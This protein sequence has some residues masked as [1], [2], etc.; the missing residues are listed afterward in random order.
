MDRWPVNKAYFWEAAP[1]FR[2][3][4]PF[5]LGILYYYSPLMAEWQVPLFAWVAMGITLVYMVCLGV[6]RT[7][8]TFLLAHI[9]LFAAG[10]SIS[11]YNDV[12][13]RYNW[14]GRDIRPSDT[15]M[16]FVSAAPQEKENTW[17]LTVRIIASIDPQKV[18]NVA[19]NAFVYVR[20][21]DV[22]LMLHKGD[23]LLLPGRW[24]PIKDAGNPFEFSY[25]AYCARNN[26]RHTQ[27]CTPAEVRLYA[28]NNKKMAAATE[29]MHDWCMAQLDRYL[30]THKAR[31][32]L[33]AMLMG[34]EVNL[35]K[36]LQHAYAETGIVHIIAIS[37]GNVA[38]FFIVIS[39][40]LG[41]LKHKRYTW[42]KYAVAMPI[43]W[44][45][46]LAAGAQPS[47]VRA[48][49]MFSLLSFGIIIRRGSNNL[50]EL[51]ATAF[52]L[53]CAE[54]AWLLS[55]GFQLSFCAVLSIILFYRHVHAWAPVRASPGVGKGAVRFL[56]R[57]IYS[58]PAKLWNVIAMSIAAEILIAP[59]VIYYFHSFP[60]MFIV[61]NAAAYLFMSIVLMQ[62][63]V[64]LAFSGI[65]AI[66]GSIAIVIQHLTD[67]FS[68]AVS[69]MQNI[70]PLSFRHISLSAIE[71]IIL[72][73]AVADM[74]Y[75][76]LRRYKPA[77]FASV[78]AACLLMASLCIRQWDT[79]HQRRLVVY[80]MPRA[81]HAEVAEGESYSVIGAD[82]ARLPDVTYTTDAAHTGWNA[83]EE[84]ASG[85]K[86]VC[87]I[88][89]KTLL[90]LDEP[91]A[92]NGSFPVDYLVLNDPSLTDVKKLS[93]VFS[94]SVIV[95]TNRFS[96][97]Q[98]AQL[99]NECNA[100]GIAMHA[101]AEQGAFVLS[102]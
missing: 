22:P 79:L 89:G 40:L 95:V 23:T 24:E 87:C 58:L 43:V 34:D 55:I 78:G 11:G 57:R 39:T 10:I 77:L 2:I 18:T 16:A 12:R 44:F 96:R 94:P 70:G 28:A 36:D 81:F 72:Y 97:R 5:A 51:F 65:P 32:L 46:V 76:L 41:W 45:Y 9:A 47:A 59:L 102:R 49:A 7:Q 4:A 66:S 13:S 83:W 63:M 15:Y 86:E 80:N 19:G 73:S 29:R 25:A 84:R 99:G 93:Q 74:A 61:A 48:A 26:I 64:M 68:A 71:T 67:I 62:G 3:L 88:G 6:S 82:T 85:K 27:W 21:T 17:K 20:K 30:G 42:I 60:V 31:G 52:V 53:L 69:A 37:G 98:L 50:N 101:V 33:Q 8:G 92:I 75:F 38:V 54:P 91:P 35:D 56:T 14:F 1:F 90:I 100:C